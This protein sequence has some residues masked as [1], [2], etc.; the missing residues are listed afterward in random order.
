[1][2]E[3]NWS[4]AKS[5]N[6]KKNC[7]SLFLLKFDLIDRN[8]HNVWFV[9]RRRAN[10]LDEKHSAYRITMSKTRKTEFKCSTR[11]E[12]VNSHNYNFTV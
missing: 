9:Y 10:T 7:F 1:M 8:L 11:K 6:C 3:L 4:M 2:F 5:E 12:L